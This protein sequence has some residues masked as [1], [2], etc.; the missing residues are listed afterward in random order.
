MRRW[1]LHQVDQPR[2]R[3][4]RLSH[5]FGQRVKTDLPVAVPLDEN[6]QS[7]GDVVAVKADELFQEFPGK[8]WVFTERRQPKVHEP[9]SAEVG[10]QVFE[11]KGHDSAAN[12]SAPP[13]LTGISVGTIENVG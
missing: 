4:P 10:A 11:E 3:H 12:S 9:G 8:V 1:W 5:E 13:N 7:H 2:R 6:S